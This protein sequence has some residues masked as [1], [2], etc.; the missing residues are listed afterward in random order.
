MAYT[1]LPAFNSGDILT[2]ARMNQMRVNER[3][4]HIVCTS[5]TR[6]ASPDTGT[7]IYETDTSRLLTY[8][9][10]AWVVIRGPVNFH[11]LLNGVAGT[12]GGAT[13]PFS[14]I[15]TNTGSAYNSGTYTFT[16]PYAGDYWFRTQVQ[17]RGVNPLQMYW[18]INGS[19]TN[20]RGVYCSVAGDSV[21]SNMELIRTCAA[22]DTVSV[23]YSLAAGDIYGGTT[24]YFSYFMG[25]S[26]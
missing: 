23:Y 26:L 19:T 21:G 3:I 18:N 13:L 22:G 16:A 25:H 24:E 14:R 9:G 17:G 15:N 6:P 4:G 2:A 5:A 10:S 1:D 12:S 11:A 8:S 20:N 7:M